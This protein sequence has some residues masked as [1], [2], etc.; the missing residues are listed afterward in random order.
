MM[1]LIIKKR[2]FWSSVIAKC[3]SRKGVCDFYKQ[4]PIKGAFVVQ[5]KDLKQFVEESEV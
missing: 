3:Y 5:A 1:F 4:N 2:W